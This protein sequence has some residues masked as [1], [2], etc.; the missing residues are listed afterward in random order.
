MTDTTLQ[1]RAAN[2][3][4]LVAIVK[5]QD[6]RV[7]QL[8]GAGFDFV[9]FQRFITESQL[10]GYIYLL[11]AASSAKEL[12]PSP[13]LDSFEAFYLRQQ[14]QNR[15][16]LVEVKQLRESFSGAGRQFILLKGLYLAK[17]F[18][19]EFDRRAFWT[20]IF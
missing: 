18:Y 8:A 15:L 14:A 7:R 5:Q 6:A 20:L 11:L 3:E 9:S 10:A 1:N 4:L 2:I 12:C 17:R 19:G 13:L 16:L